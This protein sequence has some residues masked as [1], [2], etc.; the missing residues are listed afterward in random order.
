MPEIKFE[1]VRSI[2]VISESPKGWTILL[3]KCK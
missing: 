1:I 3:G 2:D